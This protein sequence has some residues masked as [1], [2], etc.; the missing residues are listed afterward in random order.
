[1]CRPVKVL[2][3]SLKSTPWHRFN[4]VFSKEHSRTSMFV[5]SMV[6]KKKK[7]GLP[8]M[9]SMFTSFC[10]YIWPVQIVIAFS[11][12]VSMQQQQNNVKEKLTPSLNLLTAWRWCHVWI[13]WY[14]EEDECGSLLPQSWPLVSKSFCKQMNCFYGV[15]PT[16]CICTLH[17][18][19]SFSL[20]QAYIEIMFWWYIK[21]AGLYS[22][23]YR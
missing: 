7:K 2:P 3:F 6:K 23:I 21:E 19:S 1:M 18:V 9:R 11:V 17:V 16:E 4:L 22:A 12:S 13:L 10:F 8:A 20:L 5:Q 14:F 15:N